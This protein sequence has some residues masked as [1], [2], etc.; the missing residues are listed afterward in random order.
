MATNTGDYR[1]DALLKSQ[2]APFTGGTIT[3][4]FYNKTTSQ[5]Y[6]GSETGVAE[7]SN[8]VKTNIRNI[9][10]NYIEPLL[11]INFVEVSDN[12]NGYGQIRYMLSNGP[13]Y[14]YESGTY[15]GTIHLNPS[16]DNNSTTNGFQGNPGSHGFVSL[17]HETLHA[18]GLKHSGDYN[19]NKVGNANTPPFLSFYEDNSTNTVMSYNRPGNSAA[20]LMP[21]DI[22]ALQYL[23]GKGSYNSGDTTYLFNSVYGYRPYDSRLGPGLYRG[24]PT[25][26]M[27]LT[28]W[29]SGGIDTL[30]FSGLASNSSGYRF[31]LSEG[32][33]ITSN[34]AYNKSSYQALGDSKKENYYTSTYGT[35]IA[36]GTTI[37][38]VIGSGSN[39]EIFGNRA[40]NKI[41]GGVGNDFL[42]G[43]AGNDFLYGEKDHDILRGSEGDDYLNGGD[44][45]DFLYGD[46]LL[47]FVQS[48][49]RDTLD[50]G[51]GNDTL[52]GYGGDDKLYGGDGNDTLYAGDGNDILYGGWNEDILYG[53]KGNDILYGGT[54]GDA[55]YGGEGN[56]TLVGFDSQNSYI[57]WDAFYGGPGSDTFVLGDSSKVFYATT[58]NAVGDG[59]VKILDWDYISDYIQ[60]HGS[61]S[62]YKLQS[63]NWYG[64]S[65][66]DMGIFY[67]NNLIGIV[68]DSTN[69][70]FVRDFKFV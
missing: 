32:G 67:G 65:A 60:V 14:A 34:N 68:E 37:E 36:Y 12:A 64:T 38:N 26:S 39:D 54:Y 23:Y 50:G 52:Y 9:L 8:A 58:S 29:D 18:L 53:E 1:I 27:K 3:Y 33:I 69:I 2:Y 59:W 46:D 56:D 28:L 42:D 17:M 4:S 15:P 16:Y 22:K 10:E 44:G 51:S 48:K 62:Q 21:Y 43:D 31:D 55:L 13:E 40:V 49:G 66:L 47:E 19:G 45:N 63:N 35:R 30:N 25:T 6:P 7:V 11:N 20:T 41:Y 57:E 70:N 5:K 24:S 61:A